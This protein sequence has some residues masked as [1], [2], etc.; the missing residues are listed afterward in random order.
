MQTEVSPQTVKSFFESTA[1]EKLKDYMKEVEPIGEGRFGHKK[2]MLIKIMDLGPEYDALGVRKGFVEALQYVDGKDE[3]YEFMRWVDD[4]MVA[5]GM[6]RNAAAGEPDITSVSK[7]S[8][9][10][11]PPGDI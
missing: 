10:K 8:V 7:S 3:R 11:L 4:D 2:V 5:A 9:D 1:V 6:A